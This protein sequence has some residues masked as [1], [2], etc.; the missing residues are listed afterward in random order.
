V[1]GAPCGKPA[2]CAKDTDTCI[3]GRCVT[4]PNAPGG[5]G[6]PCMSGPDCSSGTCAQRGTDK[7]CVELCELGAGQCPEGFGCLDAS[8]TGLCWPGYDDGTGGICSAGG[9]GG[10]ITL[11]LTFAA[12]LFSRRRRRS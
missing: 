5:L 9:K 2:D 11:G 3:G 6:Q 4:G 10:A 12:L 8:G 7:Y 1:I